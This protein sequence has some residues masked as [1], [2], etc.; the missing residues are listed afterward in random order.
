MGGLYGRTGVHMVDSSINRGDGSGNGDKR[1]P[2]AE[3]IEK[4]KILFTVMLNL[5]MVI[6]ILVERILIKN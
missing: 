3:D 6:A 5:H 2:S 1:Q 4:I